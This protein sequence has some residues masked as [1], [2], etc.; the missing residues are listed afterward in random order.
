[1][2]S[3]ATLAAQSVVA[4]VS[5]VGMSSLECNASAATTPIDWRVYALIAYG[6]QGKVKVSVVSLLTISPN[7][8]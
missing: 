5:A 7:N 6:G 4:V 1:M 2:T 8:R 3:S